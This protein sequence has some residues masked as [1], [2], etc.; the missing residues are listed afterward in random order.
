[1]G[2]IPAREVIIRPIVTEKSLRLR[3]EEN[4]YVFEVDKRANKS[5]VKKAVEEIFGVK[6][7]KVHIINVKPKPKRLGRFEGRRSGWKKAIV[8]L[9]EGEKIEELL[10][11]G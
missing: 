8:T 10:G 1:M 2:E 4:K 7:K 11:G 6:V 9:K 3:D 5:M